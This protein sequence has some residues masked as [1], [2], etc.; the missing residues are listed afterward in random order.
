MWTDQGRLL[1]VLH[2]VRVCVCVSGG[3]GGGS[4]RR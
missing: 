1:E 3:G 4:S 2:Q